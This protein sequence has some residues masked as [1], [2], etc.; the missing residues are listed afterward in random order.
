MFAKLAANHESGVCTCGLVTGFWGASLAGSS[1]LLSSVLLA[2][3]R[4]MSLSFFRDSM[5]LLCIPCF[6]LLRAS[7]NA[8]AALTTLSACVTVGFVRYLC[9][10]KTVSDILSALVPFTC[11]MWDQ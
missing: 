1:Q 8:L 10:K 11:I 4:K 9:L 6:F 2:L 3:V 7:H 5:V